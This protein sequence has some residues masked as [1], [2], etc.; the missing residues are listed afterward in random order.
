MV[1][2]TKSGGSLLG[3]MLDAHPSIVCADELGLAGLLLDGGDV[4]AAMRLAFRNSQRELD[5]GRVTSRR[6][7]PYVLRVPGSHQ[8]AVSGP[9]LAVGDSRA[10]PTTR[11]LAGRV[12]PVADLEEMLSPV[13]LRLLHIVRNPYDPIAFM[14]VRGGRDL[15]D[16]IGDY[17]EQCER[18]ERLLAS[19]GG[20]AHRVRYEDLVTS[21]D[22]AVAGVCRV[23][24]VEV[25]A[26]HLEACRRLVRSV[27][28]ER[29]RIE[30]GHD[31]IARVRAVIARHGFLDGYT[32]EEE[33]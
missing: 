27:R 29:H 3:G 23:L 33:G 9:P 1:G 26:G 30:W 10:G 18:V 31:E 6:V 8:G 16:A 19:A 28:P 5:R 11:Y 2:H 32:F 21:P 4:D 24:D 20:T 25:D 17:A 7:E 13:K 12:T 14:V 15:M 22:H